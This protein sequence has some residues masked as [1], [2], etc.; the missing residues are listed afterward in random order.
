MPYKENQTLLSEY[1]ASIPMELAL[2]K[3]L[4]GKRYVT[5]F[6]YCRIIT[7][8]YEAGALLGYSMR[9]EYKLDILHKMLLKPGTDINRSITHIQGQAKDQLKG[10][11]EEEGKEP[12]TFYDFIAFKELVQMSKEMGLSVYDDDYKKD[13]KNRLKNLREFYGHKLAV[14]DYTKSILN[15]F[16]YGIGFGSSFPELTVEMYKNTYENINNRMKQWTEMR[17]FGLKT[18]KPD[19][20]PFEEQRKEN[21]QIVATYTA[22]YYPELLDLLDLRNYI[23]VRK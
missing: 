20:I 4:F 18:E 13:S 21:L 6:D 5:V 8:Q 12:D 3:Q 23:N 14:D 9:N 2:R 10:F 11:I 7:F 17:S 1:F 19:F 15:C 16:Y 22:E